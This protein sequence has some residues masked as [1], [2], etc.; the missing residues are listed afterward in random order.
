[1]LCLTLPPHARVRSLLW[2]LTIAG[3]R[4]RNF[5]AFG[6]IKK[7]KLFTPIL[8]TVFHSRVRSLLWGLAIKGTRS[9]NFSAFGTAKFLFHPI[10][11]TVFHF[12]VPAGE[13]GKLSGFWDFVF[14]PSDFSRCVFSVPA[15]DKK[16]AKSA[17]SA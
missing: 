2:G 9:R 1:M 15:K 7:K 13:L 6:T 16:S 10:E 17:R 4:S 14:T 11:P 5:S 3:T 8:P 12:R